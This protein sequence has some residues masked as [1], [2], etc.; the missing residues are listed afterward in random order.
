MLAHEGVVEELFVAEELID[1]PATRSARGSG[2]TVHVVGPAIIKA[3]SDSMTPQGMVAVATSPLVDLQSIVL[4]SGLVLV[5]ANI[6]DPGN[7]GTLVRTAAAAGV[8]AIVLTRGSADVLNP[9]TARAAAAALFALPVVTDV[10]LP[11]ALDHLR[12]LG[13]SIVGTAGQADATIYGSD[14]TG[15]VALVLGNEAWGLPAQDLSLL[16]TTVSIPMPGPVESLNVAMAG[17]IAI[18]ESL[19]QRRDPGGRR[20]SS[21]DSEEGSRE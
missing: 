17:S 8:D 1:D 18:F 14:L 5:L 11:V 10:D 3:I 7:V 21:A 16:D 9:K 20:L 6:S 12:G 2:V 4:R 19:R 13:Y 15:Q